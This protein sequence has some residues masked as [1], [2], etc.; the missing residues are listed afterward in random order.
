MMQ[1]LTHG[2]APGAHHAVLSLPTSS[3]MAGAEHLA[4]LIPR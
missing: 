4:G 2:G 1:D 3:Q